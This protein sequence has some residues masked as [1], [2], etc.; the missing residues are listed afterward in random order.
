MKHRRYTSLNY[1]CKSCEKSS[2]LEIEVESLSD[3]YLIEYECSH[4]GEPI[5]ETD[6]VG[7]IVYNAVVDYYLGHADYLKDR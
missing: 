3:Y 7:K 4:C 2:I 6:D 1:H 5:L